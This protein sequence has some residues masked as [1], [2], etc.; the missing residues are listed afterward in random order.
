MKSD[1]M[2]KDERAIAIAN[3]SYSLA[4]KVMAFALLIDIAYRA[5]WLGEQS[6]DL[7]G[8]VLLGGLVAGLYQVRYR[9]WTLGWVKV[10]LLSMMIA[11]V[12]AVLIVVLIRLLR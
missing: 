9:T 6:W 11:V 10:L 3:A 7:V 4:Y 2:C 5:W 1:K 12:V 8:I